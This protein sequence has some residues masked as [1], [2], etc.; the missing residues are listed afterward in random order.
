MLA[1]PLA[2]YLYAPCARAR[3]LTC[4]RDG[5]AQGEWYCYNCAFPIPKDLN[6]V[7]IKELKEIL[8]SRNV[9]ITVQNI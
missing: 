8:T 6:A 9:D 7:T 4:A 3:A 2:S 1:T 5:C